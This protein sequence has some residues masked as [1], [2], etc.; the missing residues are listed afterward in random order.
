MGNAGAGAGKQIYFCRIQL[1]TMGMPDISA[2]PANRLGIIA[3]PH[4]KAG[5]AVVDIF[6]IFGKMRVQADTIAARHF[7]RFTHQIHGHRK[8]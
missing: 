1:H 2:N 4:T 7:G 3:G 6:A 8:R 5:K